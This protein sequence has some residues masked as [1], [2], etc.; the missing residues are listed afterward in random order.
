MKQKA[1]DDKIIII[2]YTREEEE[3]MKTAVANYEKM[4]YEADF[5]TCELCE[6]K[7]HF[8]FRLVKK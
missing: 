6:D 5:G 4:G 7:K 3:Q 1:V 8:Q 2:T